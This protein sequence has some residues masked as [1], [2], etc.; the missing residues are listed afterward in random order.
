MTSKR[1]AYVLAFLFL[2]GLGPVPGVE[3]P[4][5]HTDVV[6]HDVMDRDSL[7]AFIRRAK[8]E[9]EESVSDA[10]G[11]YDFADMDFRPQGDWRQGPIYIFILESDGVIHFHGA[12]MD[13]EGVSS[14]D[15]EDNNGVKYT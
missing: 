12:N 1:I 9:V 11:V 7:Q 2:P 14:W 3:Q 13:L 6:A 10:K 15:R 8:A 4:E 5:A